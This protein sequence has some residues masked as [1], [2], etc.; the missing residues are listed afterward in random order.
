M[1][2]NSIKSTELNLTYNSNIIHNMNLITLPFTSVYFKEVV[3]KAILTH[4]SH[5][6]DRN[7]QN[8]LAVLYV[9]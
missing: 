1:R 7:S 5:C 4:V 9:E 8:A 6:K 2:K 3:A